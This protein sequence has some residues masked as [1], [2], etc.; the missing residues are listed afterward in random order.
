MERKLL[1][2]APLPA[3][4]ESSA[5][6]A[7]PLERL[8]NMSLLLALLPPSPAAPPF[9][10]SNAAC[11][12]CTHT[13][14]RFRLFTPFLVP[15]ST[16]ML[17]KVPLCCSGG[18]SSVCSLAQSCGQSSNDTQRSALQWQL[19]VDFWPLPLNLHSQC[20]GCIGGSRELRFLAF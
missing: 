17:A 13:P 2:S 16:V 5:D 7:L 3:R 1:A 20:T 19:L 12:A 15:G 10:H 18:T 4:M 6:D 11:L 8:L 9:R 14:Q